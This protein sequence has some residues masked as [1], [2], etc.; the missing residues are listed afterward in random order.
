MKKRIRIILIAAVIGFISAS[1]D[2]L[3]K[4]ELKF[5]NE[6]NTHSI[7]VEVP[8]GTPDRFTLNKKIGV[9]TV[10]KTVSFTGSDIRYRWNITD[11][12]EASSR[13]LVAATQ[14]GDSITFRD[15]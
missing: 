6:S 1:C 3:T 9:M 11:K 7:Y 15:K 2:D 14:V 13:E 10:S 8:G 12:D 4:H 5:T